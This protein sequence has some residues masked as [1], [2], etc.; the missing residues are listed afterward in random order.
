MKLTI[1]ETS[2]RGGTG[3]ALVFPK[4]V[5]SKPRLSPLRHGVESGDG[6]PG[7]R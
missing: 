3:P 2:E 6:G 7:A 5:A 4:T 1:V